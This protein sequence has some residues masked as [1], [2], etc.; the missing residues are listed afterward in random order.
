MTRTCKHE[1][2][3]LPENRIAVARK[4]PDWP[5]GRALKV[6]TEY[7][8]VPALFD[9]VAQTIGKELPRLTP[10]REMLGIWHVD[11]GCRGPRTNYIGVDVAREF[12]GNVGIA[13]FKY[14][15][16]RVS[17]QRIHRLR[18]THQWQ[19]GRIYYPGDSDHHAV[20]T[21]FLI[22]SLDYWTEHQQDFINLATDINASI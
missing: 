3:P 17:E 2:Q 9:D 5:R 21:F 22:P 12:P 19:D 14:A 16:K 4:R 6:W 18:C 8:R 1:V 20:H 13:V 7:F 15:A 10:C 11:G